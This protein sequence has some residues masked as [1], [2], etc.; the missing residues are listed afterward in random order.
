M[1]ES[2]AGSILAF[3]VNGFSRVMP[4]ANVRLPARAASSMISESACRFML[5][6]LTSLM[7]S[8]N[9]SERCRAT[10]SASV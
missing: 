8:E 7:F 4:S 10:R 9:G 6:L 2:V 3:S 5:T 1:S